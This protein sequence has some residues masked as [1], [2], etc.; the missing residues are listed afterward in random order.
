MRRLPI[1]DRWMQYDYII[2]IIN[3]TW[4]DIILLLILDARLYVLCVLFAKR[5]NKFRILW[6]TGLAGSNLLTFLYRIHL[7]KKEWNMIIQNKI[8]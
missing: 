1:A 8:K 7:Y 2:I 6:L 4:C 5:L 3:N